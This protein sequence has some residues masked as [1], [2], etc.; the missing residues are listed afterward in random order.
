MTGGLPSWQ[1]RIPNKDDA[2]P[3]TLVFAQKGRLLT[4]KDYETF[5]T[6]FALSRDGVMKKLP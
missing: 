6:G 4:P 1:R 2:N 5:G 3:T